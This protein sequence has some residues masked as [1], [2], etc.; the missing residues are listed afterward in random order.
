MYQPPYFSTEVRELQPLSRESGIFPPIPDI[1]VWNENTALF[2]LDRINFWDYISHIY[3]RF[4]SDIEKASELVEKVSLLVYTSLHNLHELF[5]IPGEIIDAHTRQK[6]SHP[7]RIWKIPLFQW[8]STDGFDHGGFKLP[9][10]YHKF[11][12]HILIAVKMKSSDKIARLRSLTLTE[13]TFENYE[14]KPWKDRLLKTYETYKIRS[15]ESID[16]LGN[17]YIAIFS[18][19]RG[20]GK[21]SAL[22]LEFEGGKYRTTVTAG[23]IFI[24]MFDHPGFKIPKD[25][26]CFR[27][28][29]QYQRNSVFIELTKITPE[30]ENGDDSTEITICL[31][32]LQEWD[33]RTAAVY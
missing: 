15:E 24:D 6:V 32:K 18:F 27:I 14:E 25:Y 10:S 19:V 1:V 17:Y 12:Q 16:L 8:K 33:A 23:R 11:C 2:R 3:L 20:P 30:I 29:R 22:H 21:L 9:Y 13:E 5:T 26:T 31:E 7:L 4:D 28:P